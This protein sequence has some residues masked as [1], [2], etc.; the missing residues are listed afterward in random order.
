MVCS[1]SM[2]ETVFHSQKMKLHLCFG[3]AILSSH[4]S[5]AETETGE[6]THLTTTGGDRKDAGDGSLLH[7]TVQ[8]VED[9]QY[10][11]D[12]MSTRL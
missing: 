3:E 12:A 6:H 11:R 5:S 4:T 9:A 10:E 1:E 2:A 7:E 8:A